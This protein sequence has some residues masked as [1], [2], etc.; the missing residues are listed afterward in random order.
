MSHAAALWLS[1]FLLLSNAF[2][3]GEEFAVMNAR[4]SRRERPDAA[5]GER[6][7][8]RLEGTAGSGFLAHL[9]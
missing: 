2:F 3:V 6:G 7:T 9:T 5:G 8:G 4:R 1:V